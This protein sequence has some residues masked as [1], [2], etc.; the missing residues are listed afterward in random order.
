M[1]ERP[2]LFNGEMVRAILDGRKTQTR[3]IVKGHVEVCDHSN[4]PDHPYSKF[5]QDEC[6]WRCSVCGNGMSLTKKYPGVTGLN[7]PFGK[8]GDRLWVRENFACFDD[9]GRFPGK[10]Q[11]LK[12]GP[13]KLIHYE[14][15]DG[16]INGNVLRPSIHMPRWA[17]R[18]N[19]EITNVR[20]ERLQD[21]SKDDAVKEGIQ[22]LPSRR[23]YYDPTAKEAICIGHYFTDP[24]D[25]FLTLWDSVYP[26]LEQNPWVWVI[27]FKKI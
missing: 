13:W 1:K 21:I 11:D 23:G 14:A 17:S 9:D 18:I 15:T 24:R 20:V 10:P 7:C 12:D 4:W 27:E 19:L 26:K 22:E 25:A 3:R 16:S 6:G 2:I 5:E 8:V